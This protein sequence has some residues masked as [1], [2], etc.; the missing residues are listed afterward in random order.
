MRKES[1]RRERSASGVLMIPIPAAGTLRSVVGIDEV[2]SHPGVTSVEITAP[3]GTEVA[4]PPDGDR[5]LGFVFAR[6]DDPATVEETL[7]WAMATIE[8]GVG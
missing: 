3:I 2:R 6:A 4:P 7:R 8:V 1:M 5:Y